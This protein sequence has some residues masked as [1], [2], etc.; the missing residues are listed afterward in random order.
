MTKRRVFKRFVSVALCLAMILSLVPG[1]IFPSEAAADAT[2]VTDPGTSA[3]WDAIM[4]T[5]GDGAR[6]AGRVW[7]DKSVYKNGDS[8]LLD[9]EGSSA[10]N[11]TL[12]ETTGEY[13][14]VVFSA[15]GSSMATN[16]TV[17]GSRPLDVVLVLDTSTSMDDTDSNRVTR[18]ER[19]IV[20]A[21]D[22]L[23]DL[24]A[25]GDIRIAIVT[26]NAD[27]ETVIDLAKYTNGIV[28]SVDNYKYENN[29]GG[30]V[31]AKDKS[32]KVL[33]KDSGY[34]RGTNLQDGIDRGMNILATA[35]ANA[36]RTPVAIVLAD[37]RANHA[38]NDDW[39]TID[40]SNRK[41]S[42]DA[43]IM[44]STLLNAAYGKTKVEKHYD[45]A[46]KVYGI[47][48]DLDD[49]SNDYIFLNPGAS[50]S[51][52]FN[53][54]NSD[55]DVEDA[56][57]AFVKWCGGTTATIV[58]GSSWGYGGSTTWTFDHRWPATGITTA[59]IAAN[60]NYV[61]N[62]QN[63]SGADLGEAFDSIYDELAVNAFNPITSSKVGATGVENTP[64]IYADNIGKY[65]EV[66]SVQAVQIFG[67]RYNVTKNADG[68]YSVAA[69][70]GVNPTTQES[71]N[72]AEDVRINVIKNG[73]GT[74]QLRIYINQEIL[75]IILDKITVKTEN[76]VTTRTIEE[77]SYPPL[78]V[79]YTVGIKSDILLP[80]GAVDISKIDS[81]YA[82]VED[83]EVSFFANAFGD[84][85]TEDR[86]GDGFVEL[87]DAHVGF[88]PSREN[89][90]YYHQAHQEIF[91]SA[92]NKN[93]SA[94]DWEDGGYGV[95]WDES[96]YSVK[97]M[98]YADYKTVS[99]DT[100][101]YTYIT[102]NRPTG[103]GN[104]AEEVTY[105]VYTTWG[106]LKDSVTFF[107]KV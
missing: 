86:N 89:R 76:G 91:I 36:G 80:D 61:D 7:V 20:A 16:T 33:G 83:G 105:L 19:M 4:G 22:L 39:Y 73:D 69:G 71:W 98:T 54:S 52:G 35:T 12:D 17:T 67:T 100:E 26:F 84:M 107:D 27:S 46:M 66:K 47:G 79:F 70:R 55:D 64:L 37:G 93:G 42:G 59:D 82:F 45:S 78:R 2:V 63:V 9:R 41:S 81:D 25:L 5:S 38:V 34:T 24:T 106:D 87:G 49:T 74:E 51:A 103:T 8:V 50:G 77:Y 13:F 18:M 11:V 99:D 104:K 1:G 23:E 102:F 48:I 14:Q 95:L 44:L 3:N 94:I 57:D 53:E 32:G 6:Y 75:P 15:L 40:S 65:M 88:V 29:R 21:N 101:V 62:Y 60:I 96:K 85:N 90:F 56:W 97:A 68:T 92:T 31:T 10:F 72:S 28:L 58:T 30:V 43:G